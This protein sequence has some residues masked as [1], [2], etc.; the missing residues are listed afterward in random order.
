MTRKNTTLALKPVALA[1]AFATGFAA[2]SAHANP[3]TYQGLE[4]ALSAVEAKGFAHLEE[5]DIGMR[6]GIEIEAIDASNVEHKFKFDANGDLKS[7]RAGDVDNDTD[8]R[9][10]LG[11][12]RRVIAWLQQEGY[13]DIDDISADDGMIEVEARNSAGKKVELTLDP[14]T[15]RVVKQEG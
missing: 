14:V 7:E 13:T 6:G 4:R 10:E 5:I 15:L 3:A 8:D 9:F 11:A 2:M 12:A 1:A